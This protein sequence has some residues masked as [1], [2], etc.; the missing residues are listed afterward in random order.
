MIECFGFFCVA[1]MV[2][3]GHFGRDCRQS[4]QVC[5][6][7][8]QV[9]H[10]KTRCPLLIFGEVKNSTPLVWLMSDGHQGMDDI[11]RMEGIAYQLVV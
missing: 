2:R 1:N 3:M 7:C 8:D 4:A 5:F 9:R 11:P 10:I 6:H